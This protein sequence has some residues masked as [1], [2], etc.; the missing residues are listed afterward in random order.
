MR[1][2]R[3]QQHITMAWREKLCQVWSRALCGGTFSTRTGAQ[4]S[5]RGVPLSEGY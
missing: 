2:Y 3:T 4:F 1:D 5:M